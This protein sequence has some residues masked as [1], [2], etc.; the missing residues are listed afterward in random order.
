MSNHLDQLV[1]EAITE[2]SNAVSESET[3]ISTNRKLQE[4]NQKLVTALNYIKTENDRIKALSVEMC[5]ITKNIITSLTTE[6]NN[7]QV[8]WNR[9][10]ELEKLITQ[11]PT[12]P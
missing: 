11:V 7:G 2:N 5:T 1:N 9:L 6:Y 4:A 8:S 10:V 3:N 12:V